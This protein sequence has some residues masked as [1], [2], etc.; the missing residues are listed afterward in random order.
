M[1]SWLTRIEFKVHRHKAIKI[2]VNV[3]CHSG[4]KK[5]VYDRSHKSECLLKEMLSHNL[6]GYKV[7]HARTL[8]MH[9]QGE[10]NIKKMLIF[11]SFQSGHKNR[12]S[13]VM[14]KDSWRCLKNISPFFYGRINHLKFIKTSRLKVTVWC[15]AIS[16]ISA[17]YLSTTSAS[18]FLFDVYLICRQ[19]RPQ[20]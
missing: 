17:L 15:L 3:K 20:K 1:H 16:D 11:T 9:A 5:V 19:F 13:F 4:E 12:N 7:K 18:F 2:K 8:S 14:V 6:F 10:R